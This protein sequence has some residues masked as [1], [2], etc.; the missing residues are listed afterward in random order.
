[1]DYYESAK[2][3]SRLITP[4]KREVFTLSE[5]TIATLKLWEL[6]HLTESDSL[7]KLQ[8][9][10]HTAPARQRRKIRAAIMELKNK[11]REKNSIVRYLGK[12]IHLNWGEDTVEDD[13]ITPDAFYR[14]KDKDTHTFFY[15]IYGRGKK[16]IYD[17]GTASHYDILK[18]DEELAAKA[19]GDYD[20]HGDEDFA[21]VLYEQDKYIV[22]RTGNLNDRIVISIWNEGISKDIL[23]DM[24]DALDKEFSREHEILFIPDKIINR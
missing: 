9:M 6:D 16:V 15:D 20:F 1:M 8:R 19:M 11:K 13:H 7:V 24:M 5:E 4:K 2:R 14:D 23:V 21:D 17:S 18:G 3:F 12:E 10:L 22:G